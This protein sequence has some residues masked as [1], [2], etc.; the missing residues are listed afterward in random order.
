M[1]CFLHLSGLHL[2]TNSGL[3]AVCIY[4]V[5]RP[6]DATA[7]RAPA[8]PFYAHNGQVSVTA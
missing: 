3:E 5:H 2:Y 7:A 6:P 8:L 1:I 4:L